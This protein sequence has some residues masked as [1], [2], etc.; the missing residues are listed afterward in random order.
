[1][2]APAKDKQSNCSPDAAKHLQMTSHLKN[3]T[4]QGTNRSAWIKWMDKQTDGSHYSVAH[5]WCLVF[6]MVKQTTDWSIRKSYRLNG[7]FW[8][9]IYSHL[10]QLCSL[11]NV[12][13]DWL[14]C[15]WWHPAFCLLLCVLPWKDDSYV[16]MDKV[17]K[18][19]SLT[20]SVIF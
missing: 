18:R 3:K 4:Q 16:K 15:W 17:C 1:M 6:A 2:H 14:W 12:T 5:R 9:N 8:V 11:Q 19:E 20:F 13:D 7:I 10:M